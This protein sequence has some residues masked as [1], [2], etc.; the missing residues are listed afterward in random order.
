MTTIGKKAGSARKA[1]EAAAQ[2]ALQDKVALVGAIGE[3]QAAVEELG[4]EKNVL[5]Q[6]HESEKD[7]L[8]QKI[9]DAESRVREAY[10]Q[11][12]NDGWT[13]KDLAAMGI[14]APKKRRKRRRTAPEQ[15][16]P[17][18][19]DTNPTAPHSQLG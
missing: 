17:Q 15:A 13:G 10:D 5:A 12:V 14:E 11:A 3:A 7:A 4:D 1:A 18:H 16:Q 19:S 2:K 8:E 9:A 6:R